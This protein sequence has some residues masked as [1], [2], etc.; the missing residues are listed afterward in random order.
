MRNHLFTN[1]FYSLII[2]VACTSSGRAQGIMTTIVGDSTAGY[3]GDGAA[4]HLARINK[5]HDVCMDAAGNMYIADM[6][7]YVIRKITKSTGIITT[8][9][10]NGTQ[11]SDGDGGHATSA[12]LMGPAY[13]C[14]DNA[15]NLFI[16]DGGDPVMGVAGGYTVRKLNLV[17]G[18]ITRVA[19]NGIHGNNGDGGPAT[20]ACL[21]DPQGICTDP[22]GNLYIADWSGACIRK[23]TKATGIISTIAGTGAAGHAGDGGPAT[24]ATLESPQAICITP[25]GDLYF[26][27]LMGEYIR[28]VTP[29]TG[30]ISAVAGN[31]GL[32]SG[33]GGPAISAGLGN[34]DGLC[35]DQHGNVYCN[36]WSCSCRKIDHTTGIINILAGDPAIDGYNGDGGSATSILMNWPA[37]LCVDP[38]NGNIII[39]DANNQRIRNTTQ[40]GFI[41]KAETKNVTMPM[42][43][44]YP[45]P[46]RG[47]FLITTSEDQKFA[48]V[49]V[50]NTA[51]NVIFTSILNNT[52]T[53]IDLTQYPVGMYFLQIQSAK[54]TTTQ[55]LIVVR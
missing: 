15:G 1:L 51:G 11:G 44:I 46:S 14:L 28:K 50:L 17:T 43:G 19:G 9:A 53:I 34:V 39:A 23:V 12:H 45:N 3:T 16:S 21:S 38:T 18:I 40:P 27:D 36:E 25:N 20:A 52:Q 33:D 31:G 42:A 22:A 48:E 24:A 47:S 30:I 55:K 41:S 32:F 10:G 54:G 37:G 49:N 26:S 2:L 8:I 6:G 29:T 4:A 35:S 13:I 7:N 5:P